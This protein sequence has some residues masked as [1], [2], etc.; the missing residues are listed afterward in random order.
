M[1]WKKETHNYLI[2][3]KLSDKYTW[4]QIAEQM[5]AKFPHKYTDEQCRHRWRTHRHKIKHEVDPVKQYGVKMKRNE[6]GTIDIDRLIEVYSEEDLKD[7]EYILR[8]NGFDPNAWKIRDLQFS[9]WQHL[10]KEMDRPATLYANKL[11]IY[12]KEDEF[13]YEDLIDTITKE[14]KQVKLNTAKYKVKDKLALGIYFMDMHFGINTLNDYKNTLEKTSYYMQSRIWEEIIV[15]FGSDLLHVDNLNNTT[16]NQTRINDV[17]IPQMI[18][19]AKAFYEALIKIASKQ[20]NK[21]KVLYI[22]GNHDQ[23]TSGLMA[24]WLEARFRE[25]SNVTVDYSIQET[26]IHTFGKNFLA[27]AHGDKGGKR[28][29][30]VL[31]SKYP[32]EWA[33]SNVRELYTGHIHHEK[34]LDEFGIIERTLPTRAKTDKWHEDNSFEGAHKR[35]MVFEYS[36][37]EL[38]SIHYV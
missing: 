2:E 7:D 28:R 36:E 20:S 19:D 34:S 25:V 29:K 26:K 37:K 6:D 21:V 18:E 31:S 12:P 3:L 4:K 17:D 15:T 13:T 14:T 35:F 24:H 27:F 38:E 22:K 5:T 30:N 10:N 9:M 33:N 23:T 11:K 32:K 16:A 1:K 8:A